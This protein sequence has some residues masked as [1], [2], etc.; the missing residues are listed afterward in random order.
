MKLMIF[1]ALWGMT[2]PVAEQIERTEKLLAGDGFT[3]RAPAEVVQRE[4]DKLASLQATHAALQERL[5]TLAR[6]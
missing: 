5:A 1:R 2:G 6:G 4:R 3:S